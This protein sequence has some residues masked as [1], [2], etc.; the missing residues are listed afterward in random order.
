VNEDDKI[1]LELL[2]YS[3][4]EHFKMAKDMALVLPLRHSKR[5][6]IEKA[7]SDILAEIQRLKGS[8]NDSS[9]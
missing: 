5:E 9:K 8:E 1:K 4:W 6:K 7:C 2:Q 3:Y